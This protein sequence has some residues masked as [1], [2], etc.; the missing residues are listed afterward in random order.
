MAD[1]SEGFPG[2]EAKT[3]CP[4]PAGGPRQGGD[5]GLQRFDELREGLLGRG[6]LI[7]STMIGRSQKPLA[8]AHG[9]QVPPHAEGERRGGALGGGQGVL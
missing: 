2:W 5:P 4:K 6:K 3:V 7:G 1:R 8:T 9:E